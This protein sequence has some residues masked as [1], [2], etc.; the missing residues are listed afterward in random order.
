MAHFAIGVIAPVNITQSSG[1]IAA[2][3]FNGDGVPDLAEPNQNPDGTA[4]ILLTQPTLTVTGI[5]PADPAQV[6]ASYPGDSHYSASVSGTTAVQPQ[7]AT[8]VLSLA[9]G[10]YAS[11][12]TVTITDSTPGATIYYWLGPSA[13]PS[14]TAYLGPITISGLGQHVLKVYVTAPGFQ[15]DL[16]QNTY[17]IVLPASVPGITSLS[18]A[19]V[20]AGG[21]SFTLTVNGSNFTSASTIEW[22]GTVLTTQ[23]VSATQLTAQVSA[24]AIATAGIAP[25][26]IQTPAPGGGTS[27]SVEFEVD[28]AGSNTPPSMNPVA[29]TVTAGTTGTYNVTLPSSATNVSVTCLNLPL[30]ATCNYS[31]SAGTL[32]IATAA[33]TPAGTYVI[34]SVFTET[35]PGAAAAIILLPLLLAPFAGAKKRK[36]VRI[37][38]W[39]SLGFAIA[40]ATASGCGGGGGGSTSTTPTTHQ[41]TSSTTITL[42]VN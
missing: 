38:L 15:S 22:N 39:G 31:A 34:T 42:V 18:P 11:V 8:P 3:D 20:A 25:V 4:A 27:N 6:D 37:L 14:Y 10:T 28:T 36:A 19:L 9:P 24:S 13:S 26:T 41:V 7:V 1:Y 30:N 32:T 21:S 23:F 5:A 12:Q 2:A 29:V 17:V 33:S 40:I 16:I 35:V